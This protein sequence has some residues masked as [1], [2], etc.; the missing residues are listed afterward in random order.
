MFNPDSNPGS[1]YENEGTWLSGP[2][3]AGPQSDRVS[4]VYVNAGGAVEGVVCYID[5]G[6]TA[7]NSPSGSAI[8]TN[9]RTRPRY[10]G[11][12]IFMH[13]SSHPAWLQLRLRCTGR[14]SPLWW[15]TV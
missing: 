14:I 13:C 11:A 8:P 10:V 5:T 1:H 7:P 2:D 9:M 4:R 12:D 6:R 3:Q 15:M